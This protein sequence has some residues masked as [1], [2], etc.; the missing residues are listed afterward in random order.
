MSRN[1]KGTDRRPA[2]HR[3]K[4]KAEL[5]NCS[6]RGTI[7]IESE[8]KTEIE[9]KSTEE[10]ML[11]LTMEVGHKVALKCPGDLEMEISFQ[12]K[13]DGKIRLGFTGPREIA[14]IRKSAKVKV[15]K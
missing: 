14:V 12:E 15:R 13:R 5:D 6:V 2:G 7:K 4:I 1:A 10:M 9:V 11:V 8:N 3:K